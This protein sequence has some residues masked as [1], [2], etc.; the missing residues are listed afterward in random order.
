MGGTVSQTSID[1]N[2]ENLGVKAV[3]PTKAGDIINRQIKRGL[4]TWLFVSISLV[5]NLVFKIHFNFALMKL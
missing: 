2:T 4:I 1:Y 3:E 5:Q